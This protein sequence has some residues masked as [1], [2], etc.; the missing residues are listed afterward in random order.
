MIKCGATGVNATL[1][2]GYAEYEMNNKNFIFLYRL[3]G[4]G[5]YSEGYN[6][7]G[8]SKQLKATYKRIK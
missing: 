6:Y 2:L 4:N 8:G 3:K 7:Y 1:D 5:T